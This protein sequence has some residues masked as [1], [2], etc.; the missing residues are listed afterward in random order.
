M[1]RQSFKEQKGVSGKNNHSHWFH[2][3]HV[4]G[5]PIADEIGWL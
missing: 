2:R 4:P 3:W 5:K 1:K